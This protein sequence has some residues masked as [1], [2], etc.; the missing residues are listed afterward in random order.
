ML[1]TDHF[2]ASQTPEHNLIMWTQ[3]PLPADSASTVALIKPDS[4]ALL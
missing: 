3:G 1:L 2:Q 4:S